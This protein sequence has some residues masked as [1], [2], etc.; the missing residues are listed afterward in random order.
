MIPPP[1]VADGPRGHFFGQLVGSSWQVVPRGT[2]RASASRQIV[3]NHSQSGLAA[4]GRAAAQ[5]TQSGVKIA[6]SQPPAEGVAKC[7]A[8]NPSPETLHSVSRQ[9]FPLSPSI[10]Q[11]FNCI[12]AG[13]RR[14]QFD[15][16]SRS[17]K[18]LPRNEKSHNR[19]HQ[20]GT[21]GLTSASSL[22]SATSANT[23]SNA[24][25]RACTLLA[26]RA[27]G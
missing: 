24:G 2:S 23:G 10:Y 17:P 14:V 9:F 25:A 16:T 5:T 27:S 19:A 26:R 20:D 4:T 3:W 21:K 7:E 15:A 6:L 12:L 1:P 13:Q 18:N 8:P 22:G 11:C